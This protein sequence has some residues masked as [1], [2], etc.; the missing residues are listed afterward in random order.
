MV[1][2]AAAAAEPSAAGWL[3]LERDQR[4]YR[5]RTGPLDLREER[6]LSTVERRQRNELRAVEQRLKRR[7]RQQSAPRANAPLAEPGTVTA[8]PDVPR[9]GTDMQ[10]GRAL[11]RER[12]QRRMRQ[13]HQPFGRQRP[14]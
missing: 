6:E 14:P 10:Q 11:E 4:T 2:C 5:Q 13:Y 12:L 3:Q 7:E 1:P 8:P 9:R